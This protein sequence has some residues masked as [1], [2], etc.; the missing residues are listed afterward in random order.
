MLELSK[1]LN[2]RSKVIDCVNSI[3]SNIYEQTPANACVSSYYTNKKIAD[4]EE[5]LSC[6]LQL[7]KLL[8]PLAVLYK[9]SSIV[10]LILM[11]EHASYERWVSRHETCLVH[12]WEARLILERRVKELEFNE[13]N[14][15]GT[16]FLSLC[17]SFV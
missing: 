2:K 14:K 15:H 5:N 9:R 16:S 7:Y 1:A 6:E 17:L 10:A 4:S 13:K 3:C 8:I 12:G 11:V